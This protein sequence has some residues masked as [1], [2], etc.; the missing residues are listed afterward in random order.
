MFW[1]DLVRFDYISFDPFI[2]FKMLMFLNKLGIK[3]VF[4]LLIIS[5]ELGIKET[6]FL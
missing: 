1:A 4:Y 2:N 3:S 5:P 6:D